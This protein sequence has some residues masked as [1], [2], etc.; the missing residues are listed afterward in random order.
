[1]GL[2]CFKENYDVIYRIQ[3]LPR[4]E[5]KMVH[6]DRLCDFWFYG[7][8]DTSDQDD[9]ILEEVNVT[10]YLKERL[11]KFIDVLYL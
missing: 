8:Y 7:E 3:E 2:F 5:P 4:G 9:Q 10:C 11:Y 1:M 6:L